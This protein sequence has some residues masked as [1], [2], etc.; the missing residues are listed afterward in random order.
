MDN[1]N[2]FGLYKNGQSI[3]YFNM[4]D[5]DLLILSEFSK[6]IIQG[7]V[8]G[9]GRRSVKI[10]GELWKESPKL[11]NFSNKTGVFEHL[12]KFKFFKN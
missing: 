8:V 4:S 11:S 5:F 10:Y 9:I 3:I 1:T 6:D 12:K 2:E 7:Y